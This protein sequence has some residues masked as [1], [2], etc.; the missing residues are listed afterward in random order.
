M[1]S[2]HCCAAVVFPL[3]DDP[4]D[5]AAKRTTIADMSPA[6]REKIDKAKKFCAEQTA[7]FVSP[8]C[9]VWCASNLSMV[10]IGPMSA[11]VV[12]VCFVRCAC[13]GGLY[14][15]PCLYRTLSGSEIHSSLLVYVLYC[16]TDVSGQVKTL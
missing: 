15:F 16:A 11:C 6:Q 10:C 9:V 4:K 2:F 13:V 7:A 12:W 1:S 5:P 3:V 14:S 8:H